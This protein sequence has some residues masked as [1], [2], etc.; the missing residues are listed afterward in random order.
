MVSGSPSQAANEATKLDIGGSH[1][2]TL[3]LRGIERNS[4]KERRNS[5]V[6]YEKEKERRVVF[7]EG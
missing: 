5:L 7:I 6:R 2:E 3:D 4:K 1:Y